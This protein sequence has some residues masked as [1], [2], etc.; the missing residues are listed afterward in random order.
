MMSHGLHYV[1]VNIL[2]YVGGRAGVG[3]L[4]GILYQRVESVTPYFFPC[5]G[6]FDNCE[7]LMFDHN[8]ATI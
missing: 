5:G 4:M 3:I 6:D 8:F 1:P 2:P 7:I